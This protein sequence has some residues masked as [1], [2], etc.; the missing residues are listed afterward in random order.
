MTDSRLPLPRLAVLVLLGTATILSSCEGRSA[1][2][3]AESLIRDLEAA[4]LPLWSSGG[5]DEV[6]GLAMVAQPWSGTIAD[7]GSSAV[8]DRMGRRVIILT[9]DGEVRMVIGRDG[10]GPGEFRDPRFTGMWGDT[11]IWVSDASTGRLSVFSIDGTLAHTLTRQWEPIPETSWSVQGRWLMQEGAVVGAPTGPREARDGIFPPLP[12]A[13]WDYE[14]TLG[15]VDWLPTAGPTALQIVTPAGPPIG[16]SQPINASPLVGVDRSG[17]WL[18]SLDRSPAVKGSEIDSIIIQRRDGRGRRIGRIAIPYHPKESGNAVEEWLSRQGEWRS[19]AL[20]E[21]LPPNL[22][23]ITPD[24]VKAAIWIPES[25]P[26]VQE[27]L[28]DEL[29]FWLQREAGFPLRSD[30][31][32]RWERYDL[33]GGLLAWVDLPDGLSGIAAR[34]DMI[35]GFRVGDLGIVELHAFEVRFP[36]NAPSGNRR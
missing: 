11:L 17:R 21:H 1:P 25:L 33:E 14:G 4:L 15:V 28:A 7:D 19:E 12:L 20:N 24:D 18:F 13:L 29:G 10:D 36:G 31:P 22:G 2:P 32:N 16:G 35:V 27:V 26:P 5:P 9:P 6:G 34:E 30:R 8:V 3:P 23:R